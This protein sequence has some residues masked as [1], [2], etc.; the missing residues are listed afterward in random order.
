MKNT[1]TTKDKDGNTL[2]I[3]IRLSDPCKNGHDDFAITGTLYESGKPMIDKYTLMCGCIHDIILETKPELKQFVD[4]HLSDGNGVP[5]YAV[6]NGYFYY[7]DRYPTEGNWVEVLSNHLR[8]SK[9]D[10]LKL[11]TQLDAIDNNNDR[12]IYFKKYVDSC[13]PRWKKEANAAIK[14]LERLI[15]LN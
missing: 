11:C 2:V 3:D 10:C 14:E 4:L 8:I 13:K 1:I 5:M 15:S 6:E 12:K 9:E 7:S